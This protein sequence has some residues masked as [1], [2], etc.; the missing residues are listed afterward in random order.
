MKKLLLS[1]AIATFVLGL[2]AQNFA[3]KIEP[4][5]VYKQSKSERFDI[6]MKDGKPFGIFDK[7]SQKNYTLTGAEVSA[8]ESAAKTKIS[9][10]VRKSAKSGVAT[11]TLNVA[12]YFWEPQW[13][14]IQML[15][16][17]DAIMVDNFWDWFFDDEE[18]FYIHSEYKIPENA[19][20]TFNNPNVI[21]NG[22]GS[23]DVP[24]GVYDFVFFRPF[25]FFMA[26]L[27]WEGTSDYAMA[28]NFTFVEGF[29]YV[30]S[31]E[32]QDGV[33]FA[34]PEDIKLSDIILPIPSLDLTAQE[35]VKVIVY[36]NGAE[37]IVG[38]IEL[39][40][41][42]N[43]GTEIIETYTISKLEPGDEIT[44]TF[45][46]KANFSQFGF[47]TVDARVEYEFDSN[48]YN[49]TISGK[50]K[51]MALIELPFVDEFDTPESM[52]NWSMIDGNGDG[53]AW[54]YDDW[55]LT[56][57]DGGKG[58]LQVLCQSYGA[59]EYLITD[60]IVIQNPGTYHMS[61][62]AHALG[63]DNIKILYGTE[64]NV[65]EMELLEVVY[66]NTSDWEIVE[67]ELEIDEPGN[68]FF[69]FHYF[70]IKANGCSGVNFDKFNFIL[71]IPAITYTITAN[72]DGCA[73]IEPSGEIIV[74]EGKNKTFTIKVPLNW[75][76][77]TS[78][79]VDG[80]EKVHELE[81]LTYT[82]TNISANHTIEVFSELGVNELDPSNFKLYPNPA[83]NELRIT[84]YEL[85]ITSVEIYDVLGRKQNA[86]SS[87]S[88]TL[89]NQKQ[90]AEMEIVI[91]VSHL[92]PG[93]Y[94]ISVQTEAGVIHSKFVVQ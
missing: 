24:G 20:Y 71:G 46:T 91:D 82:F 54:M 56:D 76:T 77:L 28:D 16:D 85:R 64:Y 78:V 1:V 33:G 86:E 66:P 79:L 9:V 94:F 35:E 84:N 21:V 74:V 39:A 67:L 48:P 93:I 70:G 53:Y 6:I 47:Y 11:V 38:N 41:K 65:E 89:S 57:A 73:E 60:P 68:Y 62:F 40:Y 10:D 58:C 27:S 81:N 22:S 7:I 36:N 13:S 31:V 72:A 2:F 32:S 8:L 90:K 45:A 88:A 69:A 59:D 61:F 23:V 14:G 55:F 19:N 44:Y 51:K 34:T 3:S 5:S 30:F 15:I 50:T 26:L 87:A 25:M 4:L 83:T 80:V 37:D 17:A 42:I 52:L 43:D 49:N 12:G 92:Q 75:C 18:L 29:E 63:N